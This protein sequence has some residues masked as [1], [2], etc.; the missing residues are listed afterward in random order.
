[1][2]TIAC[3]A[4]GG[5]NEAGAGTCTFCGAALADKVA[6]VLDE[7]EQMFYPL[8]IATISRLTGLDF[9]AA[10]KLVDG[11][12]GSTISKDLSPADADKWKREIEA[13][14]GKCSLGDPSVN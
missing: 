3:R 9:V 12:P 5:D 10:K 14:G 1:M 13:A 2:S 8:C 11:V 4:C 6:L 7:V